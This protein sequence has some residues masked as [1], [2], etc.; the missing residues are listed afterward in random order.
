MHGWRLRAIITQKIMYHS[1]FFVVSDS[2]YTKKRQLYD[3][4]SPIHVRQ[5]FDLMLTLDL[6]LYRS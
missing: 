4:R 6:L 3:S 5:H 2:R 1:L